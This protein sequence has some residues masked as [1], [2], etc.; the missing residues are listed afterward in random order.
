VGCD[1]KKEPIN[2][3]REKDGHLCRCAEQQT[4]GQLTMFDRVIFRGHLSGLYGQGRFEWFLHQQDVLL[5]DFGAYVQTTSAQ[6]K[7]HAQGLAQAA[8][9]PYQYLAAAKTQWTGQTKEAIALE[10]AQQEGLEE[11]LVCVLATLEMNMSY[12]VR[13]NRQT[14]HK[15]VIRRPRKHLHFYFYFLDPEFGLMH[16]RL[17]SWFP[18]QV[19]VYLNGRSWL[20][21]QLDQQGIAYQRYHNCFLQIA[22]LPAA[23]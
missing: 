13:G 10:I 23:Q 1:G 14:K 18:F 20:A 16:I 21:Q 19:Q 4:L 9:R 22:D 11:G 7:A 15:E 3:R 5:K 2:W 12:D 8:G 17:Q 6:L